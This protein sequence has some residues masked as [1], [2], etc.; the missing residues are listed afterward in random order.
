MR[1]YEDIYSHE[2][3]TLIFKRYWAM[4]YAICFR[5]TQDADTAKDMVQNIFVTLWERKMALRDAVS[6]EKYLSKAAKYQVFKHARDRKDAMSEQLGI[7]A[8]DISD[9]AY[10]TPHDHYV[11]HEM[12]D[13]LEKKIAFLKEPARSIFVM[14]RYESLTHKEIALRMGIA[15]KTVEYH[16]TK[17]LKYIRKHPGM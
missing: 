14:S 7:T 8:A 13:Q 5:Y 3:F 15:V 10:N 6:L 12:R 4:V 1:T 2:E 9:E 11:Y 17:A 16:L